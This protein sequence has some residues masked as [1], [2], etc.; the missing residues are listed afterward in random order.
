MMNELE[1]Q[2]ENITVTQERIH[3]LNRCVTQPK[4]YTFDVTFSDNLM[5]GVH[6]EKLIR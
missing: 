2:R 3:A 1:D 5:K 6:P 4:K